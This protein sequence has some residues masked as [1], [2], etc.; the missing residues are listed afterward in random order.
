MQHVWDESLEGARAASKVLI[1]EKQTIPF[2]RLRPFFGRLSFYL[3]N[4]VCFESRTDALAEL[5]D[6]G[7]LSPRHQLTRSQTMQAILLHMPLLSLVSP[8][9]LS[10]APIYRIDTGSLL[11]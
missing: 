5:Q 2:E 8:H 7:K 11:N 3:L 10:M 6:R 4:A 9:L 1:T